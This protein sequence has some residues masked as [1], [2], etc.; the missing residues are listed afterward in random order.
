MLP[1]QSNN[2]RKYE[3]KR[4]DSFDS[5]PKLTGMAAIKSKIQD[6]ESKKKVVRPQTAQMQKAA[7]IKAKSGIPGLKS[8]IP[9]TKKA[10]ETPK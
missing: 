7:I 6:Q 4:K 8:G 5:K 10:P 9:K 2:S 3:L 1:R